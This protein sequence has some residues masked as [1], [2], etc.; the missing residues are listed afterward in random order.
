MQGKIFFVFLLIIFLS[1]CVNKNVE[2]FTNEGV[3]K[4]NVEV[5]NN[6]VEIS[7]GLMYRDK[8]GKYNG[9][10]FVFNEERYVSF[11]MKNTLIPLDMIFIS[12]N[13]TINEIKQDIQPCVDEC[14]IYPSLHPSKYVLEVNANF[15]KENNISVGDFVKIE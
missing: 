4:V 8:L 1:G 6:D 13:G 9:M 11:W 3:V 2:I 7:K 14:E 10:L 15:S 5:A 12:A